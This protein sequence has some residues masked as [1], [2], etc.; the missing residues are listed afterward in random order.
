LA[1]LCLLIAPLTL[2]QPSLRIAADEQ[3]HEVRQV[4]VSLLRSAFDY[5]GFSL[6]LLPMPP[7]R[8]LREAAAGRVDGELLHSIQG[9]QSFPTLLSIDEP[10]R[11]FEFWVWVRAEASCPKSRQSLASLTTA[12]IVGYES[13][14][15]IPSNTS[16]T[17]VTSVLASIRMLEA[18]RI[19]FLVTDRGTIEVF[20]APAIEL[21]T[22]FTEPLQ[23]VDLYSSL[24]ISHRAKLPAIVAGLKRAKAELAEAGLA[25]TSPVSP[26]SEP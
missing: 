17:L 20:K 1:L 6:E 18:K 21:K 11:R 3:F 16:R 9:L 24:H 25:E 22:C 7:G 19:D 4:E 14:T 5:A 8:G 15:G 23:Q 10:L 13:I 12:T 2:A 26:N